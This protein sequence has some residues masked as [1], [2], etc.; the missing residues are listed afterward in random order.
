M[1]KG[2]FCVLGNFLSNILRCPLT[3]ENV[4]SII[5]NRGFKKL[6]ILQETHHEYY[7]LCKEQN[8]NTVSR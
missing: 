3:I 1:A 5:F 4:L 2:I 7:Y 8:I 6:N